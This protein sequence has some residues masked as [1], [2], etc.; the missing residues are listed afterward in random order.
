MLINTAWKTKN[1]RLTKICEK[2][3][4]DHV[5]V[6]HCMFPLQEIPNYLI[7]PSNENVRKQ[8]LSANAYSCINMKF[9]YTV[10]VRKDDIFYVVL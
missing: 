6:S 5:F 7:F 1:F 3:R 9:S 10:A 4:K 8:H 2:D